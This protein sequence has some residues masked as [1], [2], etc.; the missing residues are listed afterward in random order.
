MFSPFGV[1]D[2][3]VNRFFSVVV[4]V[5]ILSAIGSLGLIGAVIY[6]IIALTNH[7]LITT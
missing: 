5:I 7:L 2:K 6:A 1:D 3:K 4:I